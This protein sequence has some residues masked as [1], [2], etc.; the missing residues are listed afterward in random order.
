MRERS[1]GGGAGTPGVNRKS[2]PAKG[3]LDGAGYP[4]GHGMCGEEPG[5]RPVQT[6][7]PLVSGESLGIPGMNNSVCPGHEACVLTANPSMPQSRLIPHPGEE[8]ED[9][10]ATC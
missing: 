6:I 5:G 1:A 7:V 3:D 8:N 9:G 4:W 2:F 10:K